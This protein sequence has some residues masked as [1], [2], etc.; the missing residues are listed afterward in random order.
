MTVLADDETLDRLSGLPMGLQFHLKHCSACRELADRLQGTT[1]LLA[2]LASEEPPKELPERAHAQAQFAMAAGMGP[3][4]RIA[5]EDDPFEDEVR[6]RLPWR[7]YAPYLAVAASIVIAAT[8][9]R[10]GGAGYSDPAGSQVVNSAEVSALPSE[11]DGLAAREAGEL[12][13]T[14]TAN[15]GESPGGADTP[16]VLA[17]RDFAEATDGPMECSFQ[18]A[19]L[20]PDPARAGRAWELLFDSR[21]PAESTTTSED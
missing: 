17:P 18:R 12:F 20:A 2:E 21:P 1:A 8:V 5:F 19:R 14:R 6:P 9:L 13:D 4:G 15:A 11:A 3:T 16:R 7:Q 10:F